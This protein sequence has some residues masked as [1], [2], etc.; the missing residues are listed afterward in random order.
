M[1]KIMILTVS[2]LF[3]CTSAMVSAQPRPPA[4]ANVEKTSST[5]M[6]NDNS[7]M[8]TKNVSTGDQGMNKTETSTPN[9][10]MK[11]KTS[12]KGG[13]GMEVK[14][15]KGTSN[16]VVGKG[17]NRGWHHERDRG[18]HDHDWR[19]C[20]GHHCGWNRHPRFKCYWSHHRH[21]QVCYRV[22]W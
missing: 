18:Y 7:K 21:E 1:K 9:Q 11:M 17:E 2:A 3:T 4:P 22:Y 13:K 8:E 16:E 6:T 10:G 5:S 19:R 20:H 14:G 15:M 12:E